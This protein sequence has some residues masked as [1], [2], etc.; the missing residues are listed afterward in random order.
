MRKNFEKSKPGDCCKTMRSSLH[1]DK[2]RC[3][4]LAANSLLILLLIVTLAPIIYLTFFDYANGDDFGFSSGVRRIIM[5]HGGAKAFVDTLL[6][7]LSGVYYSWQGTWSSV[8][9]FQLQPG[10]FGEHWYTLTGWIALALHISSAWYALHELVGRWWKKSL[11]VVIMMSALYLLIIFWF[12]PNMKYGVYWF[13]GVAHYTIPYC[14][15]LFIIGWTLKYLRTGNNRY[16]VFTI[17]AMTYLG[18]AGYPPLVLAAVWMLFLMIGAFAGL[19]REPDKD[20]RISR[21][22]NALLLIPFVLEMIGFIISAAAPGNKV[23]GGE[24]FGFSVSRVFSTLG[25]AMTAQGRE[26]VNLVTENLWVSAALFLIAFFV[27]LQKREQNEKKF[28]Y[29][30]LIV[31]LAYLTGAAVRTPRYYSAVDVSNGVTDVEYFVL[32]FTL[33]VSWAYLCGAIRHRLSAERVREKK[34]LIIL[35][36]LSLLLFVTGAKSCLKSSD[37]YMI[38]DFI[39]S[40]KLADYHAQMEERIAIL[41]CD[42]SGDVIVPEMNSEQGPFM[43]MALLEDPD[44]WT[45]RITAA[46]YGKASV[47]AVPRE[48]FE[49]MNK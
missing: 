8:L 33:M 27:F 5:T 43:H 19:V 11:S 34:V 28:R 26:L 37:M 47:T 12:M 42:G 44:S 10:I 23:R 13:N 18:G 17:P 38:Y 35:A 41:N 30:I 24:D 15:A 7:E 31:I 36:G 6:N 1:V 48:K 32:V 40:G 22:R 20:Q 9:L 14:V 2:R 4:E 3:V 49:G 21:R 25:L 39:S 46:Y 45:N 29:P 16:L